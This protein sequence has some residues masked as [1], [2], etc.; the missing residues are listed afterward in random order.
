MGTVQVGNSTNGD[1]GKWNIQFVFPRVNLRAPP[2]PKRTYFPSLYTEQSSC[3]SLCYMLWEVWSHSQPLVRL[4]D[5]QW[6][7]LDL[8]QLF[9][10]HKSKE[11]KVVEWIRK[12]E[13]CFCCHY[14]PLEPFL[15]ANHLLPSHDLPPPWLTWV[16]A[17]QAPQWCRA[18]DD[19]YQ[20]L[21]SFQR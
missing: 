5:Y 1:S 15:P 7:S 14:L 20:L 2:P 16:A 9:C 18:S 21:Q 19:S 11:R 17:D 6:V 8:S 4:P 13:F 3:Q 10:W 12:S